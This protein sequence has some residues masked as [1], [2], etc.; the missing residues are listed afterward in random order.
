MKTKQM[1]KASEG[2][3]AIGLRARLYRYCLSL[4]RSEQD[5]ED[6]LQETL[7][8]AV[9]RRQRHGNH[10]NPEALL[11]RMAKNSWI[12]HLRR[13]ALYRDIMKQEIKRY[14]DLTLDKNDKS[15]ERMAAA[16]YVLMRDLSP[17][18]RIV[19]LLREVF[20]FSATECAIYLKTT[21]GAV[22]SLLH[23][24][25]RALEL[26]RSAEADISQGG[27]DL[28]PNSTGPDIDEMVRA[29]VLGDIERLLQLVSCVESESSYT[30]AYTEA[31]TV[32]RAVSTHLTGN[33]SEAASVPYGT[34]SRPEMRLVS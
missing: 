20:G 4:T 25:R 13:S 10:V 24:A 16:F 22:K 12:D 18:Q 19:L 15:S 14:G 11:L 6:L 1:V 33:S 3:F 7:L 31:D 34:W 21:E 23:R 17:Q 8:K 29:Y 27:I 5:A 26:N 2:E 32:V 9:A 30:E 28:S